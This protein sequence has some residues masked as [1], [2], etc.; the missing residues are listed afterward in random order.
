MNLKKKIVE[1][2]TEE[3]NEISELISKIEEETNSID[4]IVNDREI[5]K[6]LKKEKNIQLSFEE[7]EK[8][9]REESRMF[10]EYLSRMYIPSS[11]I[12]ENPYLVNKLKEDEN[13]LYNLLYNIYST[14]YVIK[15]I[16][17]RIDSGDNLSARIYEAYSSL[18]K[19]VIELIKGYEVIKVNMENS[20]KEL[21]NRFKDT[22]VV[23][24][25]GID[26]T[27]ILSSADVLDI[28]D[29]DVNDEEFLR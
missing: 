26:R 24:N 3:I 23:D 28:V 16:V 7:I 27:S 15:N 11:S 22:F 17:Y 14:Q 25:Y 29:K 12:S 6:M 9:S 21:S 13:V 19:S 10:V 2:K 18:Q 4:V 5:E 8:C 1:S 20:Y